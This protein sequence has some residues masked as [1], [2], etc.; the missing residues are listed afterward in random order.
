MILN[1]LNDDCISLALCNYL[2]LL[3]SLRQQLDKA[4]QMTKRWNIQDGVKANKE[5]NGPQENLRPFLARVPRA[6]NQKIN[7]TYFLAL[8]QRMLPWCV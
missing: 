6:P 2:T 1:G 4:R 5:Q 3:S 8:I 7:T